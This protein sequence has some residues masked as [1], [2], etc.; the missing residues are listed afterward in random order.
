MSEALKYLAKRRKKCPLPAGHP[1]RTEDLLELLSPALP[2]KVRALFSDGVVAVAEI[3]RERADAQTVPL[4][5][6]GKVIELTSGM[7]DFVGAVLRTL[8]GANVRQT[9]AGPENEPAVP[10]ESV[11]QKVAAVFKWYSKRWLVPT[12][13]Y[14]AFAL[15]EHVQRW[16]DMMA[17]NAMLFILG[18]EIGHV[19]LEKGLVSEL[20]GDS[21]ENADAIGLRLL[22]RSA[23]LAGEDEATAYGAAVLAVWI[24]AALA[25]L[26]VDFSSEYEHDER[27]DALRAAMAALCPS[28][29]YFHEASR[30]AVA[31][32]EMMD[33]VDRDIGKKPR[34]V[35]SAEHTLVRLIAQ[36][37]DVEMGRRST[38]TFLAD[39]THPGAT[40]PPATM[41][42]ALASL[43]GYYVAASPAHPSYFDLATRAAMGSILLEVVP[44]LPPE[45]RAALPA[46]GVSPATD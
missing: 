43:Y 6:G 1:D 24:F 4:G 13:E 37:L 12:V 28:T 7:I 36:L 31:F 8:G 19:M 23:Q 11:E 39:I 3:G 20:T 25:H 41:R 29:Q 30:I 14:P 33:D 44:R 35:P 18:H 42:E 2:E 9:E 40:T 5:G 27:I 15:T 26:G 10:L 16:S 38:E 32:Q 22:V 45:L 46:A 34:H 17:R 21:E